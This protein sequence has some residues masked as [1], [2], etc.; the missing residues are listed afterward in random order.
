MMTTATH[1]AHDNT[2][3]AVLF[4]AFELR[5]NTWKLGFSLGPGHKPRERTMAARDLKR[6]L[7]EGAHAKA[8]FGLC[9][10]APVVSCDEA[11]RAGFWLHRFLHA[12][13][14][15]NSVVD[16][17]SLAVNRRQRR[18]KS[19]GLDVRKLLSML[20]RYQHGAR[21][22]WQVVKVPSVE[23]E[24]HRHLHR[25]LETLKQ[26]RARTTTRIQG[27]LRSQGLRVTSLP[28]VPEPLEALRLWDGSPMPLGLRR[29][30]LRVYAHDTLLSEQI[31][32]VEVGRRALL[33][34][35][36]DASIDTGRQLMQRKGIGSNGA[37]VVVMAFFGWRACKHRREVGGVAGCTPTPYH[38]GESA[39]E[40]G[41]TKAGNR[42][43][44]W[45]TTANLAII[46]V[47][48]VRK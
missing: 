29:R 18:A 38:S 40:P 31:A 14:L 39:R 48:P 28:K 2:P 23:A 45:M 36:P 20:R 33:Q 3:E 5:E 25:D 6:L 11:G 13:G 16:S 8:R 34:T 32:A 30:V 37:W 9:A 21:Q 42:H 15:A 43:V 1:N 35:S 26:E 27:L 19:D 7:D 12:H 41:I 47:T 24:D 10:T 22:G 44:R 17:S 46:T 4:M